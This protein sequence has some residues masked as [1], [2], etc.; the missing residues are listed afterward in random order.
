MVRDDGIRPHIDCLEGGPC[1]AGQHTAHISHRMDM[2]TRSG[3]SANTNVAFIQHRYEFTPQYSGVPAKIDDLES[4][5]VL[6]GVFVEPVG[7]NSQAPSKESLPVPNGP[8]QFLD[9]HR[10]WNMPLAQVRD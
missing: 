5:K 3:W 8:P 10:E 4:G 6:G 1:G 7:A 2:L 9:L